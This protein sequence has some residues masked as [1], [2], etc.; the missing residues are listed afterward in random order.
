MDTIDL[1]TIRK[2]FP[3]DWLAVKEIYESG[4]ATG[5]ATFETQA[6]DWDDWDKAHLTFGRMVAEIHHKIIAWAALSPV[7]D[8]C[9]YSGVAEI[10]IYV[11]AKE[12]S[13][14]IGTKL[15]QNLILDSEKNGVWTLQAGIF[16][17]NKASIKLHT[18]NGFR[19]MG[20]R[21]KIGRL[22]G[23]WCDNVILERRSPIVGID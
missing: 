19:M 12:R 1:V 23:V 10:S 4:I 20:Y 5:N 2:M 18:N 15:L 11:N 6:P 22:N 21:E 14:G 8:R 3:E 17:E 7:S 13:K 9:V 16:R